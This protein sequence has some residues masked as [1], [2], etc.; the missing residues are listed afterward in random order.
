MI[1]LSR[2]AVG[3]VALRLRSAAPVDLEPVPDRKYREFLD[4]AADRV[5]ADL[6]IDVHLS[7]GSAPP[8]RGLRRVFASGESWNMYARGGERRIRMCPA[9]LGFPLWCAAFEL[10][11]GPVTTWCGERYRAPSGRLVN[12]LT[13][14]LDIVLL[15]YRLAMCG[16]LVVHGAGIEL[17]G[18]GVL[19]PARSGSGKST[20]LRQLAGRPDTRFLGD[21]R[22]V[23]RG[24]GDAPRLFGTPWLGDA[25]IGE[26]RSA[27][28][29]AL[30]FL[31]HAP[32]DSLRPIAPAE[33]AERLLPVV[34]VPW[35]DRA[36]VPPM[37]AGID[38]LVRRIPAFEL[39]FRPTPA[40]GDVLA[41]L[42]AGGCGA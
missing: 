37:V 2:L 39:S 12:P 29:M 21:D 32:A 28:L 40:V 42:A 11:S 19:F 16:G 5:G 9:A 14:P 25:G 31:R 22:A 35:F 27:P 1:T 18:K 3:G 13:Y 20:L 36:V 15:M 6:D 38:A 10:E 34:S 41:R 8:L 33:A 26:N 7:A 17:A 23:L 24:V 30:V 4:P